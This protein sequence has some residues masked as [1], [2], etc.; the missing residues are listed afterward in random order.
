VIGVLSDVHFMHCT[1]SDGEDLSDLM[2]CL[3]VGMVVERNGLKLYYTCTRV[4]S[5]SNT[6]GTGVWG[7]CLQVCALPRCLPP[8]EICG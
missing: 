8:E 2:L 7:S 4:T 3:V 5:V 6:P 1:E